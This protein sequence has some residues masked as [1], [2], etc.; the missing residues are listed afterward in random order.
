M[1]CGGSKDEKPVE[2][3]N[4]L[5]PEE[6]ATNRSEVPAD[7]PPPEPM[8]PPIEEPKDSGLIPSAAQA[9]APLS[10]PGSITGSSTGSNVGSAISKNEN[11]S[12]GSFKRMKSDNFSSVSSA[13]KFQSVLEQKSKTLFFL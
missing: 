7:A 9:K 6:G 2:D 8:A 13:S 5:K 10:D 12:V 4:A 11:N 1:G 3:P